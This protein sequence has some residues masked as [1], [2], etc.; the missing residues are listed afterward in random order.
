MRNR[1]SLIAARK[2][3]NGNKLLSRWLVRRWTNR[4]PAL[5][6]AEKRCVDYDRQ[7]QLRLYRAEDDYYYAIPIG[8]TR[9]RNFS[10]LHQRV[11]DDY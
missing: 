4:L 9:A 7:Y 8:I 5:A 6:A 1:D 10:N 2:F 11:A 3:S